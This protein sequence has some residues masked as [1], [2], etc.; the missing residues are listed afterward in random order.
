M[1][2]VLVLFHMSEAQNTCLD[3]FIH[4]SGFKAL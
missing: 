2:N 4:N 3:T 1:L